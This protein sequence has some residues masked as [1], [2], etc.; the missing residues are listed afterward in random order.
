SF[1]GTYHLTLQA[2]H[3]LI[4]ANIFGVDINPYAVEVTKFSLLLKL[5]ENENAGSID[6]FLVKYGQKVLPNLEENIK[7]GNS[8]VDDTYFE[9]DPD[10]IEDDEL[11]FKLKP[12]NW[13]EEF[14]FLVETN[15]FDAIVGNPPYV[16]IQNIVKYSIE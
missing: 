1:D 2:K 9:Y 12:F 11:L 5:L 4:T 14:P 15:G 3:Q 8:L 16:R 6:N 13:Y 7:C 10:A